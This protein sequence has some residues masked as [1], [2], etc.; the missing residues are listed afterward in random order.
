MK[1][2]NGSSGIP[3]SP[4]IA[5]HRHATHVA[6]IIQRV[7]RERGWIDGE[8]DSTGYAESLQRMALQLRQDVEAPRGRD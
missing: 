4:Q 7:A 5:T 1:N 6:A 8:G 2:R 3:E